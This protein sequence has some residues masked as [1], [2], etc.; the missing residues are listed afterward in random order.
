MESGQNSGNHPKINEFGPV[1]EDTIINDIHDWPIVHRVKNCISNFDTVILIEKK[2]P[3]ERGFIWHQP[4][5]T[6]FKG[7]LLDEET[8]QDDNTMYGYGT[9]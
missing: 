6:N 4:G 9:E 3:Y 7:F 5:N 8:L 1:K 2:D